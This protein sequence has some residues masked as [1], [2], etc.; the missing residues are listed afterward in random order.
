M[1]S[2]ALGDHV[3]SIAR[4]KDKYPAVLET[5]RERLSGI[6]FRHDPGFFPGVALDL[7]RS[8]T[9]EWA[10]QVDTEILNQPAPLFMNAHGTPHLVATNEQF[11]DSSPGRRLGANG[12]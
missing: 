3:L 12:P 6:H 10:R 2:I 8:Y 1:I 9:R 4:W 5:R 7:P 11:V